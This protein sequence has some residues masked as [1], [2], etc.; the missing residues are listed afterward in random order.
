[1]SG[2]SAL[3]ALV[4]PCMRIMSPL[5]TVAMVTVVDCAWAPAIVSASA[6]ADRSVVFR[7]IVSPP[8]A[9][10]APNARKDQR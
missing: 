5:L 10:D 4:S 9:S 2:C 6:V 3:K 1:M 7:F 8:V